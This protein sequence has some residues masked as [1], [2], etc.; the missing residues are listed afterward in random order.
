MELLQRGDRP[1]RPEVER[2]HQVDH[3]HANFPSL[4]HRPC[5]GYVVPLPPGGVLSVPGWLSL[6]SGV[7]VLVAAA[8]LL[9]AVLR[10]ESF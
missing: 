6:L 3:R 9:Y 1:W 7:V 5:G 2:F 10:P 8:Y 4:P